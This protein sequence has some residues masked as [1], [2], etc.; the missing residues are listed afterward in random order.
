MAVANGFGIEAKVVGHTEPT[1]RE[2]GANQLVIR[3]GETE[4]AYALGD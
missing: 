2:D 3:R 1:E 4:L